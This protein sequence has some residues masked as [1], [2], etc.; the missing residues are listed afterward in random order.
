MTHSSKPFFENYE[1]HG[2]TTL[3]DR[4]GDSARDFLLQGPLRSSISDRRCSRV[5]FSITYYNAK[6]HGADLF[7]LQLQQF[8]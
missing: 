2:G 8:K 4:T 3:L 7:C 5:P 6:H 1:R